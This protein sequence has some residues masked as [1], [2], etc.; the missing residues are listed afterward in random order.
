MQMAL[1]PRR[2]L[3]LEMTI[4]AAAATNKQTYKNPKVKRA[5]KPQRQKTLIPH[6]PNE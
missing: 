3:E 4:T 6:T 2:K 1:P 5:N